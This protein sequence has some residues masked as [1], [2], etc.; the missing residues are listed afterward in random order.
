M[1]LAAIYH[2]PKSNYAIIIDK[3]KIRVSL[4]TGTDVK[5]VKIVAGDPYCWS[6]GGGGGNLANEGAWGWK[7]EYETEMKNLINDGVH[8][9]W[10]IDMMIPSKRL[11]YSFAIQFKNDEWKL[12]TEAG[13]LRYPEDSERVMDF[14]CFPYFNGID[15][16]KTPDWTK[17]TVWYQIFPDRFNR[18][19]KA[20]KN[21]H[22]LTPWNQ[23]DSVT[24]NTYYGGTINGVT[25]KLDYLKELGISG[26]YFTPITAGYS[27]HK[28]DTDDY[29]KIDPDFG[30]DGDFKALVEE[31]HKRGIKIMLDAVFNHC[32]TGFKPFLDV[33]KK[34]PKS[35]YIDWFEWRDEIDLDKSLLEIQSAYKKGGWKEICKLEKPYHSF[36]NTWNMPKLNTANQETKEYLIEVGKYWIEKFDIDAWRL[37]V[38][39]EVDHKFWREFRT[40]VRAVKPDIYIMGEIWHD[41]RPWLEGDQFD[42]VMNYPNKFTIIDWLLYEKNNVAQMANRMM[43]N[44]F[45]YAP[46]INLG[47]YN[48]L[49]SHDTAR[50]LTRSNGSAEKFFLATAIQF[51][52]PGSPSI[53]YGDEIGMTGG[54]DPDCRKPMNWEFSTS[55]KYLKHYKKLIRMT[56]S[57]SAIKYGELG[58]V[59]TNIRSNYFIFNRTYN[60]EI[61]YFIGSGSSNEQ[62][63][64][65]P[66]NM[67]T[68][69]FDIL[70]NKKI[71]IK[72][73]VI[74]KPYGFMVL[75]G[76]N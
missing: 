5:K 17:D 16:I 29:M 3:S 21:K 61:V 15:I 42:A 75:K 9:Y 60:N 31:A 43:L 52:L 19:S 46:E 49:S 28:Y 55:N 13:F 57:C 66:A 63:V 54:D 73:N 26:I 27:T 1:N 70:A 41:S 34:G 53:Y 33:L 12:Y 14:F 71:E 6:R 67:P 7:K 50:M 56:K 10:T 20:K 4:R 39:N 45:G 35:K 37:D 44:N 8:K 30:T 11:R 47:T 38:S 64:T 22:N 2:L 24:A 76:E 65:L 69:Y 74:I 72:K 51:F 59:K 25:E 48:L 62:K 58:L 23:P 36:A 68:K 32:G 18:D 40:A